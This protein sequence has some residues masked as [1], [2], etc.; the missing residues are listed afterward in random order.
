MLDFFVD[1][2]RFFL[3]SFFFSLK[4]FNKLETRQS[5]VSLVSDEEVNQAGRTV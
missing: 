4:G 5:K 2:A 3:S 1:V